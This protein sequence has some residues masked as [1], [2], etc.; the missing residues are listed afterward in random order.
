MPGEKLF[1]SF[2]RRHP[3]LVQK[4]AENIWQNTNLPLQKEI[5][6]SWFKDVESYLEKEGINVILKHLQRMFNPDE[7]SFLLY[8]KT[9][10]ILG[11]KSVKNVF[12]IVLN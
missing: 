1:T 10:K 5:V 2:L 12:Y 4:Q 8:P 7:T 11:P 6:L 9:G 3:K